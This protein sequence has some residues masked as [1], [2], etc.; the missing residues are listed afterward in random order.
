MAG[1]KVVVTGF[2]K[3]GTTYVYYVLSL[4]NEPWKTGPRAYRYGVVTKESVY[5]T[6]GESDPWGDERRIEVSWAAPFYEREFTGDEVFVHLVR[7]PVHVVRSWL[8][9]QEWFKENILSNTVKAEGDTEGLSEADTALWEWVRW[10]ERIEDS[11]HPLMR[12]P[13]ENISAE[14]I[15][16]ILELADMPQRCSDLYLK[17][18][19]TDINSYWRPGEYPIHGW[20]SF[21]NAD[22]VRRARQLARSYGYEE[23]E[24]ASHV[25]EVREEEA[26]A[27]I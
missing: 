20:E 18:F 9:R 24:R 25:I 8:S 1:S 11:L 26:Q 10:N 17:L 12:L 7:Y 27:P 15:N 23:K 22:L 13:V 4:L 16:K 19:R 5:G 3:S 14:A 2:P 21:Q 6:V